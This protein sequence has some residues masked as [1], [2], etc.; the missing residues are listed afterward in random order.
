MKPAEFPCVSLQTASSGIYHKLKDRV[1]LTIIE[2]NSSLHDR[3]AKVVTKGK[4]V[5]IGS[6]RVLKEI[7]QNRCDLHIATKTFYFVPAGFIVTRD[8]P[9]VDMFNRK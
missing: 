8:F 1:E 5:H 6:L 4:Y 3:I 7:A 2:E 9:R